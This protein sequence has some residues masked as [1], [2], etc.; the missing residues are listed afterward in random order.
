MRAALCKSLDGP[1][2]IVVEDVAAPR[3][4]AG[5]VLIEVRATALNFFDTLITR[6]K[7]QSKPKLPFSPGGEVAGVI[8][9]CGEGVND[10]RPGERVMAYLG[11]GG[12]RQLVVAP[13]EMVVPLPDAVPFDVAAGLCITYGTAIHGLKDRA[14]LA[15]GDSVAVLGAAGGAGLAAV[16]IAKLMGAQVIA[17]ASSEDK[18]A[19]AREHGADLGVLYGDAEAAALAGALKAATAKGG[20]DVIYDCIGGAASEPAVRALAWDGRLLVV[21][22]ASGDIAKLPLN[23]LMV[24]GAAAVGVFWGDSVRRDPRRHRANM[25]D[26]LQ[27]VAAGRLRPRIHGCFPLERIVEALG[28]IESRAAAGKVV[29]LP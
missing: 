25:F 8:A 16:E 14:A 7:Y 13:A 29:I 23:L 21:G 2:A 22:F 24:K 3:P 18:L 4:E 6:G 17:V 10:L 28:I 12:A 15:A 11:Y 19:I 20:V 5:E 9:A 27:W 1:A 26:L